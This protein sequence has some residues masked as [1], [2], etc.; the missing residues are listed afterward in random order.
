M[1]FSALVQTSHL[2]APELHFHL[3]GAAQPSMQAWASV[4]PSPGL[5]ESSHLYSGAPVQT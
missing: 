2:L 5:P 1:S 4:V 3:G